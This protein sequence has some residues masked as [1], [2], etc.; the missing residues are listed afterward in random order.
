MSNDWRF[1]TNEQA[2]ELTLSVIEVRCETLE[3]VKSYL[4]HRFKDDSARD[5]A[6]YGLCRR[7][8]LMRH[9]MERVFELIPPDIAQP[10]EKTSL[11]DAT[12]FLHAFTINVFGCIDNLAHVWVKEQSVQGATG[13]L[14]SSQIG[15]SS[16]NKEVISSLKEELR[17]YVTGKEFRNWHDNYLKP[18]RH[19]LAHRI[20]FFV[21]PHVYVGDES[22]RIVGSRIRSSGKQV[23]RSE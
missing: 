17:G 18:W 4:R 22:S 6:L 5:Y 7:L 15:F 8:Y 2:E 11:N 1:Y 21:P 13:P 12:A 23:N 20:P 14:K 19:P 9:C 16:S 10:P 3:L